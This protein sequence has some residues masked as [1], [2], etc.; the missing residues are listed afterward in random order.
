MTFLIN[1]DELRLSGG[2]ARV[3]DG[4]QYGVQTYRLFLLMRHQET[5][6]T[7]F[8]SLR[9]NLCYSGGPGKIY[10]RQCHN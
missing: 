5:A 1:M 7:A 4:F 2:T 8:A 3:F 6:V 10:S 9:G